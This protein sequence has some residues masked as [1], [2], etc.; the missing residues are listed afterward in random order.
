MQND[1]PRTV[2]ELLLIRVVCLVCLGVASSRAVYGFLTIV[3]RASIPGVSEIGHLN[4]T[5]TTLVSI[6]SKH[7]DHRTFLR[8]VPQLAHSQTHAYDNS[9]AD[10]SLCVSLSLADLYKG[11]VGD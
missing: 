10:T 8:G 4:F 3:L 1:V 5:M 6:P 9:V 11:D 2:C 7:R